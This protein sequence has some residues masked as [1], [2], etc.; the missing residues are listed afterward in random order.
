[1]QP[2]KHIIA[3]ASGKGGVGKST[4]A[5]NLAL[6]L[7]QSGS[8]VGLLD[9]DIY[10]P[11]AQIMLAIDEKP[12]VQGEQILPIEKM[13]LKVMSMGF[14]A[15]EETP[16]I[17]RGPMIAGIL[18]Q[19]LAQVAW[20]SLDYLV[21]DMPPGTGDAQLTLAQKASISGAVIVTTPQDVAL[22]DATRG[23]KMFKQVGVPVLGIIENMS[24]FIC[25][26]CSKK[27]FIFKNGGGEKTARELQVPFLGTIPVDPR[28]VQGGD[29]GTPILLSHPDSEVSRSFAA[30]AEKVVA[31]LNQRPDN[32]HLTW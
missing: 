19:F 3:V 2:I 6:A 21:I 26:A 18:Q 32:L 27:H 1:M 12:L 8:K 4:V 9:A 11:S 28:V 22:A 13:G 23:L 14:L 25:D 5:L 29:A 16:V 30:L 10:G 24:Y 31:A 17:W 7:S 20:G 15:S